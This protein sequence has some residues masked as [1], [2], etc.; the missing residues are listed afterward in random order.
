MTFR[1]LNMLAKGSELVRIPQR[2]FNPN[3]V[4]TECRKEY[5][6]LIG[7]NVYN[8]KEMMFRNGFFYQEFRISKL[9]IDDVCPMLEEVRKFQVDT[10]LLEENA[11]FESDLDEWDLLKDDTVFKT[12]LNEKKLKI[13][14]GDRC[15]VTEGQFEGCQGTIK[16]ISEEKIA[17]LFTEDKIPVLIKV[18]GSELA[19]FFEIG[20]SVR[21]LQG[22]HSGEPGVVIDICQPDKK[23]A[24]VLME[25]TKA[26]LKVLITNLCKR[27]ELDPNSKHTLSQFLIENS[28]NAVKTGMKQVSEV[29]TAGDMVLFDNYSTLGLVLQVHTDSLKVLTQNNT[30]QMIKLNQVSK[31]FDI[32]TR[33]ISGKGRMRR[34]Q[35][36]TDK[37]HNSITM[38]TIVK[39]IENGPY[40]GCLGVIRG[41]FKDQ[42]FIRLQVCPN[43]YLLREQHSHIAIRAH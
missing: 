13:Q 32:E 20:E 26:E 37:F 39:P 34:A 29:F 24:I 16:H 19:K 7:K 27:E 5:S 14:I 9:I 33:G 30:T 6:K 15:K 11:A 42:L 25:H 17:S 10:N 2:L 8:W 40:R 43:L 38:G 36:I 3:L 22:V 21:I 23:H 1:G 18:K 41:I 4:K 35:V 12:I 31:K 28:K